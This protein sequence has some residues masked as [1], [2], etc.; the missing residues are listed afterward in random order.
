MKKIFDCL[1][2]ICAILAAVLFALIF[3]LI[4]VEIFCRTFLGF[5]LLWYMDFVQLT[6]C[7][8]L[9]FGMSAIV[10]TND[11]LQ[12][13]F[14]KEKFPKSAQKWL[15][16]IINLMELAFFIMLVPYG[17]RTAITKMKISITTLHW[18]MGYMFAALPVFGALCAIFMLWR[19]YEDIRS[20][21]GKGEADGE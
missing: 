5:S 12:I 13:T 6:V 3:C 7:W 16:V 1:R 11:H 17:I 19:C 4:I 2:N 21:G 9:A 20:L 8:M 15:T 18:P 10:Y 14:I